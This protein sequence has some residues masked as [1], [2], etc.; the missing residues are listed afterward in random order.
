M[1]V[2][3]SVL[4]LDA[5]RRHTRVAG[6]RCDRSSV[7]INPARRMSHIVPSRGVVHVPLGNC[8]MK[9]PA[10]VQCAPPPRCRAASKRSAVGVHA[11]LVTCSV[12]ARLVLVIGSCLLP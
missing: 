8:N 9:P 5:P 2:W 6:A 1:V 11:G 4:C 12:Y 3:L 10:G 7:V